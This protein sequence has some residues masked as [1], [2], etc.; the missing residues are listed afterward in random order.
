MNLNNLFEAANPAQQAAIAISMKKAGKKPKNEGAEFGAYYSEQVAQQIFDKRQDISSEEEVLNQAYHI[1]SNDQG[2][3]SARYMFNY[4]EDFPG[5]VVSNYFHLQ[6]QGVTEEKVRLDPKCWTGKKI[7]NPKTKMKGGVRV[8]N[9]VPAESINEFALPGGGDGDSGRWYT[10]DELADIIGDDWFEDFDVSNDGFNIDTHGEKAKQNLAS[11]ANSWFD[12]KGYNVNVMGVD[13]NEVDHDLKWYI[14]GSFQN[15]NFADKDVDEGLG[16]K[17]AGLGL[18]GA[19]ALGSAG[20]NARVTPDGQGGFTGGLKPSAT[21]T[22]PA[23]NKPAAEA[24]KG[25]SK[26]YL[27]SVVDGKHPR[28]MVSVEKAKELLKNMQ[29][30]VVESSQRVDSLVTDALKIMKGSE[31]SDAVTALKTVLGDREYNGRRGHYNF[32]V[33]QMLDMYSQQGV[34]EGGYRNYDDNR[35]GF[36]KN[37]QAYRADGGANDED[38]ELDRRRE[39]QVQSGTWYIRLNGKLIKD[40]Q[41]NPYSFRGKAAA[42]KA[43]LTMQAKL[44]NQG[45]EFMLTTNPNDP[46]QGVTEGP[47]VDAYMAGKSP[48]LAHFADQLD[49]STEV[50]FQKNKGI[51]EG[52]RSGYGRGYASYKSSK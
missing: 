40:K 52:Q 19:M 22:A 23:D 10:D 6:K 37:S 27:Q 39:Q 38:H 2:Q 32:Y 48:A 15:D 43:A 47:A 34:A 14:V 26:E 33:R 45:K 41:G 46:Q 1:V 4:D 8:N 11:Y 31:A 35:T 20:A 9:C 13:H 18:A 5:D 3:K 12:D 36:S 21:V 42:N 51:A 25:F 28:P 17:L 24:P 44:F 16:S 30:G 7:G 50:N 29:E 49:K